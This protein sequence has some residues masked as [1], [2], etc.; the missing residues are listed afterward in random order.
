[1]S[2][3][4]GDRAYPTIPIFWQ[5]PFREQEEREVPEEKAGTNPTPLIAVSTL[6]GEGD[7][8]NSVAS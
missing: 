3:A 5:Y 8:S 7:L 1:M 6:Y 2:R 4:G